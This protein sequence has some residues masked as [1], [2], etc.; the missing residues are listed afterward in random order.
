MKKE[1]Y[2][3]NRE[4]KGIENLRNKALSDTPNHL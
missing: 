3:D 2:L 1:Y 4:L